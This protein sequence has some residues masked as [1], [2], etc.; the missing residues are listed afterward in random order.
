MKKIWENFNFSDV[1]EK[2]AF[3]YL[4]EL[5]EPLIEKTSGL[6]K[7][8]VEAVDSYLDEEPPRLVALYI[9]YVVATK[10]GNYRKKILTVVEYS[11]KGRFPV[12]IMNHLGNEKLTGIEA[13]NFESTLES[14]LSKPIVKNSIENLFKQSKEAEK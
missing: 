10:L 12:D 6:L 4:T 1:L 8:E 9:L 2:S 14:I 11:D 13:T 7:M 3:D 5:S